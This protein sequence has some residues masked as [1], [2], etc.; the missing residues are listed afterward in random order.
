M[1]GVQYHTPRTTF[2]PILAG[3]LLG[4][5]SSRQCRSLMIISWC[6]WLRDCLVAIGLGRGWGPTN[7]WNGSIAARWG[8]NGLGHLRLVSVPSTSSRWGRRSMIVLSTSRW[9]PIVLAQFLTWIQHFMSS[10]MFA[11]NGDILFLCH[12][13]PLNQKQDWL[14]AFPLLPMFNQGHSQ[15]S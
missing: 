10:A 1:D 9:D 7:I 8:G 6:P 12:G 4:A 14:K 13:C 3:Q 15:E 11:H 2:P 5:L